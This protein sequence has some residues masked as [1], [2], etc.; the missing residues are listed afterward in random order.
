MT[1][2]APVFEKIIQDYLQR[3]TRIETREKVAA[4]LG[5]TIAGDGYRV[6]FFQETY[7]VAGDRVCD[8]AGKNANHTVAVILCQC[9]LLCPATPS[10]DASLVTYKDFRDAA[11]YVGGFRSTVEQ[12]IASGFAHDLPRLQQRSL[13]LGGY[14][15]STEVSCDLSVRFQAL[16][17]VPVLLLFNDAD[18]E[19][20][21]QATILF[22]KNAAS[23]LDMECL[24][25]IGGILAHRLAPAVSQ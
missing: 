12:P 16:P 9:L 20:P 23:Y 13:E 17:K 1:Q 3:I 24:A 15:V 25:M 7:T 18:A 19:F 5:V 22:Q 10:D 21:A 11:P 14:I 2:K 8:A 4:S 6:P